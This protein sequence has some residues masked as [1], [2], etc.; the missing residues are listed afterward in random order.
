MVV[1]KAVGE[2]LMEAA[3]KAAAAIIEIDPSVGSRLIIIIAGV[4]VV[5]GLAHAGREGKRGADHDDD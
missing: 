3:A 2:A 5:G 4:A 1:A